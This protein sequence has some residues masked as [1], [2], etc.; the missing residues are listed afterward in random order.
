MTQKLLA[1]RLKVALHREQREL[2]FLA[3]VVAKNGHKLG[4]PDNNTTVQGTTGAGR[5]VHP[6][7]PM[8]VLASLLSRFERQFI[9]D[10]TGLEG[11]FNLSLQWI[12]DF[13]RNRPPDAAPPLINGQ[14]VDTNGPSIY[15][16][17][18]EQLGLRLESRK[19]PVD[20]LVVD[21]AQQVPAEN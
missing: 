15:T 19:G 21:Q 5:I 20:V 6:R 16:A 8:K 17:L 4:P 18:P 12:P 3:L 11:P 13:L 10:M 2:P 9:I 14:P 7:L 1:E